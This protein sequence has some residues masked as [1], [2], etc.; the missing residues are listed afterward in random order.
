MRKILNLNPLNII[1]L[2]VN[3]AKVQIC[4]I[5]VMLSSFDV[6]LCE[7]LTQR[8]PRLYIHH[9]HI[10]CRIIY[11]FPVNFRVKFLNK[12][13]FSLAWGEV[14]NTLVRSENLVFPVLYEFFDSGL[15]NLSLKLV[16]L[17]P[18]VVLSTHV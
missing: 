3:I 14:L 1:F 12:R 15:S 6:G 8:T 13:T 10:F 4:H 16:L 17:N 5:F 11:D 18:F 7:G 9:H 2:K